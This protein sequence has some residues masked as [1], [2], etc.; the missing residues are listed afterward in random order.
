MSV[1]VSFSM[2]FLSFVPLWITVLFIDIKSLVDGGGDKWTEI[3]GITGILWGLLISAIILFAKFFVTDDEKYTLTIQEAKESKTV[4]AEFLLSYI[5]P[6]FTFDFTQWDEVI[7]FL[8]FFI[9]FGYL[10]IRHNNFSVNII[11]ELM[12]YKIAEAVGD[13]AGYV[14][15]KGLDE[16]IL[17][18]LII[19]ALKNG[20]QKKADIYESVKHAFSDVLTEEKQ[21]KKLS[22]LL[23]KMKKEG[24]IDVRGSAVHAEWFLVE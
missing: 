23:Q 11:L 15:N 13:K 6:L 2:Y 1:F 7:K 3:I 10:C 19:S 16:K 8:L 4:T 22:N 21:Y 5:L 9:I 18:E 20:P 17:K 24:I 14:R 12:H